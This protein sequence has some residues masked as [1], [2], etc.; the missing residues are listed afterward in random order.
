[1]FASATDQVI[2]LNRADVE[3]PLSSWS[4]YPFEL[5][6]AVWPTVEHYYQAMK[7]EDPELREAVRKAPDAAA[8]QQLAKRHRRRQRKDWPQ[9]KRTMMTRA[10]YVKCRAWPTLTDELLATGELKLVENSQYD[11]YW[12]CGRDLRGD[13]VYGKVLMDVRQKLRELRRQPAS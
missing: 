6:G 3:H 8:A 2:Y 10:V 12:G 13:N 9:L 4:A 7:F 11:Y 1:M 5:D